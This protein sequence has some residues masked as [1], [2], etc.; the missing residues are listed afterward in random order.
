M[1]SV[2]I[3]PAYQAGQSVGTVVR[4]LLGAWPANLGD[5]AVLVVDDGSDDGTA[6]AAEEAGAMVLRHD[7]NRGKGAALK[8]GLL[9]A[10]ALGAT[11]AVT[12]D[13]DGQHPAQEAM[14]LL[15]DPAP[16]N[17][18]VLGVRNLLRDGAPPANRFSNAFSNVFLSLFSRRRL[19]DTQCGLRRY[20]VEQTLALEPRETGYGFEAE[21]ILR[22]ARAG[23][24]IVQ[25]PVSVIYPPRDQRVSHFRV[26]R[27]PA[28]IVFRVLHTFATAPGPR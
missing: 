2:A 14:H 17:A 24:T 7:R 4:D 9:H 26:V 16:K 12:V 15:A 11:V 23:W 10:R 18:L 13:A 8:S 5:P 28:R 25:I 19:S 22:A 27:D 6:K 21:V 20:P 1:H 3:V